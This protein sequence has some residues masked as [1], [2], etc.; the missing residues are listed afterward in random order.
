VLTS[1]PKVLVVFVDTARSY[2]VYSS[3][4]KYTLSGRFCYK[5]NKTVFHTFDPRTTFYYYVT[6][7][8]PLMGSA[9]SEREGRSTGQ[10]APHNT[11]LNTAPITTVPG[12]GRP[13]RVYDTLHTRAHAQKGK[14]CFSV[15]RDHILLLFLLKSLSC[16]MFS[17]RPATLY[18][19]LRIGMPPTAAETGKRQQQ[20]HLYGTQIRRIGANTGQIERSREVSL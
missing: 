4:F 3:Q 13:G 6:A 17:F 1:S 2:S 15:L 10:E 18:K 11:R 19:R 8:S 7:T 16:N 9:A 20:D 5:G 12:R 14:A